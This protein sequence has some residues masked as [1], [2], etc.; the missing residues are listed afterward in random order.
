[1]FI[2]LLCVRKLFV[3]KEKLQIDLLHTYILMDVFSHYRNAKNW[4]AFCRKVS[5]LENKLNYYDWKLNK[6]YKHHFY[7]NY[8]KCNGIYERSW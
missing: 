5:C 7:Y 4:Y 6:Q 8:T 2:F 3:F 1:M